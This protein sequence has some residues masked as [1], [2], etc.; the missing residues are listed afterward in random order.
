[1]KLLQIVKQKIDTHTY[2]VLILLISISGLFPT[3]TLAAASKKLSDY[4]S[5]IR[6]DVFV[7]DYDY[8]NP[9]QKS[10]LKR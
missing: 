8:L 4:N 6:L 7:S 1:M 9:W 3:K 10:H 5:I 2:Y